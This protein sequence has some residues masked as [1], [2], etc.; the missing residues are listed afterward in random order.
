MAAAVPRFGGGPGR[1]MVGAHASHH[2]SHGHGHPA[3]MDRS[4]RGKEPRE[5]EALGDEGSEGLLEGRSRRP[6]SRQVAALHARFRAGIR[7]ERGSLRNARSHRCRR[8]FFCRCNCRGFAPRRTAGAV[9][10][11]FHSGRAAA[12]FP[13]AAVVEPASSPAI[14]AGRY[15]RELRVCGYRSVPRG[16]ALSG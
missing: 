11:W 8:G 14:Q 13:E 15:P 4:T 5:A 7:G 1:R 16:L 3:G 6:R 12:L 2:G 10:D 9:P